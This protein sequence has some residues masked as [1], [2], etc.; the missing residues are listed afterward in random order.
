MSQ[1]T[2]R[3]KLSQPA[4]IDDLPPEMINELFKYLHP[5]DLAACSLVNKRWHSIYAGFK[6][7]TLAVYEN[8]DTEL[9]KWSHPDR[10]IEDRELVRFK[11][12]NRLQETPLISSLK[13]LAIF[14][15]SRA[16]DRSPLKLD[17]NKLNAFSQLVHL[18]IHLNI[19][20]SLPGEMNLNLPKLRVLALYHFQLSSMSHLS[21]DCPE[22]RV[23]VCRNCTTND[24]LDVK[25]PETIRKLDANMV[26]QKLARFKNVECLVTGEFAA[27]SKDTLLVLTRLK[28]LHYDQWMRLLLLEFRNEVDPIDRM[29]R[30]LSEFLDHAKLLRPDFKCTFTGFQITKA[31]LDAIDFD[32][33]TGVHP[34]NEY[35]YTRNWQL[36]DPVATLEFVHCLDYSSLMLYAPEAIPMCYFQ[37]FTLVSSVSVSFPVEDPTHFLQ[38]LGSLIS[39]RKL[40][41]NRSQLDREFYDQL[42]VAAPRLVELRVTEAYMPHVGFEFT[43][44]LPRLSWFEMRCITDQ[45]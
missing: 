31:S 29:K 14:D 40:V 34:R 35:I 43:S 2:K 4:S 13:R 19:W 5:K 12:F 27:I 33:D 44:R 28:E 45:D 38:F 25:H 7:R 15:Q 8:F 37:K 6:V 10:E 30:A 21:I 39:L 17:P 24:P 16:S 3:V 42:P 9:S 11:M 26:G 23:L 18:E 32:F 1:P 41:L 20:S 22:L 36:V